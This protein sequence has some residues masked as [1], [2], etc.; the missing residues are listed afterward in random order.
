MGSALGRYFELQRHGTTVR[1]EVT[2]G[3]TTFVGTPYNGVGLTCENGPNTIGKQCFLEGVW[4]DDLESYYYPHPAGFY[5]VS[6]WMQCTTAG[7]GDSIKFSMAYCPLLGTSGPTHTIP[8]ANEVGTNTANGVC[9][10]A[11]VNKC[12]DGAIT[13]YSAGCTA[14]DNGGPF[15]LSAITT[16]TNSPIITVRARLEYLGA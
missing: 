12:F 1:R 3:I 16:E 9:T 10:L 6:V 7:A 2:A 15:Y 13:F 4:S 11:T 5:R 8:M 14:W